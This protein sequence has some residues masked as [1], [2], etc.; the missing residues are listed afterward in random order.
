MTTTRGRIFAWGAFAPMAAIAALCCP[1]AA[2]VALAAPDN[3]EPALPAGPQ[4]ADMHVDGYWSTEARAGVFRNRDGIVIQAGD[5]DP[6]Y[7]PKPAVLPIDVDASALKAA[8]PALQG[9][10]WTI[11]AAP[12][13]TGVSTRFVVTPGVHELG[14]SV[15]QPGVA[16]QPDVTYRDSKA[17]AVRDRLI[18]SLGDSVAAGEGNPDLSGVN[19]G[20]VKWQN[21]RCHRSHAAYG[22]V[23][24]ERVQAENPRRPVTFVSFACSGAGTGD[25]QAIAIDCSTWIP[26]APA[27]LR[28]VPPAAQARRRG[29]HPLALRGRGDAAIPSRRRS[30]RKSISCAPPLAGGRS[31]TSSS[32]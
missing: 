23:A 3:R 4:L 1:G 17:I 22:E 5:N 18:V 21:T 12:I 10:T 11:D 6:R 9:F 7:V 16:G 27:R 20:P 14:L 15:I 25:T 29:R 2:S 30:I 24:A 26:V 13:G 8:H 19:G 32:R 31:T 28:G